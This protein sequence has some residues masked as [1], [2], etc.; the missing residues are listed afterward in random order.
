MKKQIFFL[1]RLQER[2]TNILRAVNNEPVNWFVICK[3]YGSFKPVGF[4][5]QKKSGWEEAIKTALGN[6]S[7]FTEKRALVWAIPHTNNAENYMTEALFK[8]TKNGWEKEESYPIDILPISIQ[9]AYMTLLQ[10]YESKNK[11]K[12]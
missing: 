10:K 3:E 7:L 5:I 6:S 11:N 2:L 1:K 12:T 8:K 9:K 4:Y